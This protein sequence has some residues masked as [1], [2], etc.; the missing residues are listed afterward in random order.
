MRRR[1]LLAVGSV[2]AAFHAAGFAKDH[3]KRRLIGVLMHLAESDPEARLRLQAFTEGLVRAGWLVERN[4][5]VVV[6]WSGGD[7]KK[8]VATAES[9]IKLS[10][11]V[12]VVHTTAATKVVARLTSTI[13]TVF[14]Q[15]SDPVGDGIVQSI[16]QP[17]GNITGF[18]NLEFSLG[19]KWLALLREMSPQLSEIGLLFNPQV[20]TFGKH[21]VEDAQR[22]GRHIGVGTH[23]LSVS[24]LAEVTES[25]KAWAEV[26]KRGLLVFPDAFLTPNRD[27]VVSLA[28]KLQL[29][30]I[31][32]FRYWAVSGALMS[33][34]SD[35][36][37]AHRRSASYVAAILKGASPSSLPV[38]Y[39]TVYQL[40][41]N[42]GAAKALGIEIPTGLLARADELLE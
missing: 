29:P 5:S 10:P 12:L 37:D 13:P 3:A 2:A 36:L 20:T 7:A 22:S 26:P 39:P 41:I 33:Y 8:L 18:T 15:V 16:R 35:A 19:G 27:H 1:T 25:L 32:P 42:R 38:Q 11:E 34:G 31:S 24:N 4:L 23:V 9:L 14:V 40:V 28:T 17:G 30:S 6:G 21:I